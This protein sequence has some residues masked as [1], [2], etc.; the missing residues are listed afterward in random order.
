MDESVT[1]IW[2]TLWEDYAEKD[3]KIN[4]ELEVT[5]VMISEFRGDKTLTLL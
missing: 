5:D 4:D 3:W 2:L 1:G